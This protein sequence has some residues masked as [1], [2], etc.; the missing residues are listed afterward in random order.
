MRIFRIVFFLILGNYFLC[1]SPLSAQTQNNDYF[2][3]DRD[4]G[5]L[6]T[7][8]RYHFKKILENFQVGNYQI[9][10]SE[11]EYILRYYPNHPKTLVLAA[12]IAKS[13]EN[14]AVAIKYFKRALNLY[15]QHSLTHAQFGQFLVNIGWLK[16]GIAKLK[17]ALKL[18]PK[19][20]QAYVWIAKAYYKNG[21]PEL[22]RQAAEHARVLGYR[23]RIIGKDSGE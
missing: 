15:P 18:D 19:L 22:A 4:E 8:E 11:I 1:C 12:S 23:G 20:M 17:D 10:L 16:A 5:L 21:E 7:I 6:Q 13:T 3:S 9:A 14:S 2:A